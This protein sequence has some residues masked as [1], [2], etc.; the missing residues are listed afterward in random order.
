[1]PFSPGLSDPRPALISCAHW[2]NER[3]QAAAMNASLAVVAVTVGKRMGGACGI[4]PRSSR[5][6]FPS[7]DK[8]GE[9]TA[10]P[11]SVLHRDPVDPKATAD[12]F[13]CAQMKMPDEPQV[14]SAFVHLGRWSR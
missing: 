6:S 12:A 8:P 14:W 2:R 5:F 4:S 7:R 11:I 13:R 1:M 3:H 10:G 9:P